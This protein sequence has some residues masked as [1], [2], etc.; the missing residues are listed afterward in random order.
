MSEETLS[1]AFEKFYQADGKHSRGGLGL[2]LT[3]CKK[4][5]E[6]F[7]GSVVCES[8]LGKGTTFTVTLP[9]NLN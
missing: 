8:K 1:H 5:A 4:I 9:Q 3:L 7:G 6:T 2:G